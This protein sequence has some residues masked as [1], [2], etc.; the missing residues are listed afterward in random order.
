VTERFCNRVAAEFLVP[1]HQLHEIWNEA[2]ETARP[3]HTIARHFK[4]SPVV[5]ARQALDLNLITK[6]Q[7]FAFYEQDQQDWQRRKA[8]DKKKQQKGGPNFYD[9][10]D[11]R[12]GRPFAY[13]VVSAV[14]SGRLLYGDAYQLTDL[15]G[16][17]FNRYANL[18][19]QRMKDE[20]R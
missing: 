19:L 9:V 8:E 5:A 4:V 10:Q 7:F 1:A 18:V 3:F 16:E 11:I 15:K 13:A 12:L 2:K 14:R 17:T 20:R 6:T